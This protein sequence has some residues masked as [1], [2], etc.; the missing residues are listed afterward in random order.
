MLP[1][2]CC[3]Q[4]TEID[5]GGAKQADST[6]VAEFDVSQ[7]TGFVASSLVF[8]LLGTRLCLALRKPDHDSGQSL[9]A[10]GTAV[11][12]RNSSVASMRPAR[13]A[14]A[15]LEF[16][17]VESPNLHHFQLIP[18]DHHQ[19]SV[20]RDRFMTCASF[21]ACLLST[22]SFR[23]LVTVPYTFASQ[24]IRNG[25]ERGSITPRVASVGR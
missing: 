25:E 13:V 16:N 8:R 1:R 23:M 11:P 22:L 17:R 21:P 7:I 3:E 12:H 4:H 14:Y 15:G 24:C 10:W 20:C 19:Q 2:T 5:C 6:A 9:G 18:S